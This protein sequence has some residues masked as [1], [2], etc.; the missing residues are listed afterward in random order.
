MNG[1]PDNICADRSGGTSHGSGNPPAFYSLDPSYAPFIDRLKARG[2]S[3]AGTG[4]AGYL[5][6]RAGTHLGPYLMLVEDNCEGDARTVKAAHDVLTFDRRYQALLFMYI[7]VVETQMRAQYAHWMAARHGDGA[8]YDKG[9]FHD[10]G[11]WERSVGAVMREARRRAPG[12]TCRPPVG[13]A[14]EGMTLGTL[15]KL[16]SNTADREVTGPVAGSF[17]CSKRE[18]SN[19]MR[20]MTDVRNIC[21]HFGC[22]AARRQLPSKPLPIRRLEGCDAASTFYAVLL[23]QRLLSTDARFHDAN[24]LYSERMMSELRGVVAPFR[25]AYPGLLPALGFP[26]RWDETAAEAARRG[27]DGR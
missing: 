19:W 26:P 24:L 8:L 25:E 13:V 10:V 14:V 23:L 15:V 18:L 17:R 3:D 5:C 7:G 2:F 4:E 16:Y 11:R 6:E 9:L 22:L 21:A 27:R 1:Q 12:G 20:V